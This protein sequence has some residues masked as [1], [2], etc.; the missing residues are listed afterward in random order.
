MK[1]KQL[2]GFFV[3]LS[4][5][6]TVNIAVPTDVI[7]PSENEYHPLDTVTFFTLT[8][9]EEQRDY[10]LDELENLGKY[11]GTGGHLKETGD[12]TGPF[13]YTGVRI[14]TLLNQLPNPP[15]TYKLVTISN[16]GYLYTFTYEQIQGDVK[17]Y[18]TNGNYVGR[19]DVVMLL[20]YKEHGDYDFYGGPLRITW[21]NDNNAVTDAPLWPKYITEIEVI[22]PSGQDS[23]LPQVSIEKPENRVYLFDREIMPSSIPL[24]I[25]DITIK[26]NAHDEQSNIAKVLVIIDEELK[27]RGMTPPYQWRWDERTL[28][29]HTL[30]AKAYDTNGNNAD[31]EIKIWIFNL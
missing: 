17:V 31:D 8:Y 6:L 29:M 18:D 21:V 11:R 13:E 23:S 22:I 28:G 16:D 5:L 19:G 25:G 4:G 30:I 15:E 3:V 24:I 12:I 14:L 10:S 9:Q 7:S 27:Y 26:I 20:A 1:N 2:I